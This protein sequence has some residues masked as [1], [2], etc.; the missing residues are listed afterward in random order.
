MKKIDFR[1]V[2][3]WNTILLVSVMFTTFVL[4]VMPGMW[5]KIIFRIGY[6]I[7]Y[8]AA[9]YSLESRGRYLIILFLSTL[10]LEWFSAIFDLSLLLNFSKGLN[11]LFFMVIVALML[12]QI[13]MAREV[14]ARVILRSITGYLLLG[15]L[16][17]IF[18]SI[19]LSTD[20]GAYS[21]PQ[22]N[23]VQTSQGISTSIPLYFSFVTLASLG[24][25]DIVPIKPLSRS[26]ATWIA[27]S[28]QFYIAII[29]SMLVGKFSAQ[30]SEKK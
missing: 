21:I 11:I 10:I 20:P 6:S 8:I 12:R 23:V 26:L 22:T 18:I 3:I 14:T 2:T 13:A 25:G 19:I 28:G 9:I 5:Q 30:R 17:S 16:Y 27:I 29:V 15:L 7:I 24:Y 4:P 1:S